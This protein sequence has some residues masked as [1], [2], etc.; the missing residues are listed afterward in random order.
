MTDRCAPFRLD[1]RPHEPTTTEQ[2]TTAATN[3]V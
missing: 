1:M 2:A 3:D